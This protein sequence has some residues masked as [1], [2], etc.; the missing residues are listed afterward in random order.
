MSDSPRTVT[1]D[2]GDN[3]TSD[4]GVY[5]GQVLNCSADGIPAPQ[6]FWMPVGNNPK[7]EILKTEPGF[8]VLKLIGTG[9][10]NWNC[11]AS[12][13]PGVASQAYSEINIT[14]A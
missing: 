14:G 11:T 13:T 10:H 3:A 8:S 5:T 7:Y 4:K 6:V 12:N 2:M 9:F 1:I